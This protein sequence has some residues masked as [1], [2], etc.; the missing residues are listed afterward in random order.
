MANLKKSDVDH[1]KVYGICNRMLST[2]EEGYAKGCSCSPWPQKS[3]YNFSLKR[4][5]IILTSPSC[6]CINLMTLN[7]T[8]QYI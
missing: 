5:T 8:L 2:G 3:F 7:Y 4:L 1:L 6:T